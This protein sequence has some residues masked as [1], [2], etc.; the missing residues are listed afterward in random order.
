MTGGAGGEGV[1][2]VAPV[3]GVIDIAADDFDGAELD[4]RW[5]KNVTSPE[6][7]GLADG[8][9]ELRL[10]EP[11]AYSE[12][13]NLGQ[14]DVRDRWV[15]FELAEDVPVGTGIWF[16]VGS[17]YGDYVE[18]YVRGGDLVWYLE[19]AGVVDQST[20][21][22]FDYMAHRRLRIR[23]DSNASSD[24][25][26]VGE[27]YIDGQ[28]SVLFTHDDGIFD[29]RYARVF[30]GAHIL[31]DSAAPTTLR[32][33]AIRAL[34]AD[35]P[36]CKLG[37]LTDD[38]DTSDEP[39][40]AESGTTSCDL[41]QAGSATVHCTSSSSFV[42]LRSK[43]I[44]D[45]VDSGATIDLPLPVPARA[46]ASLHFAKPTNQDPNARD[47]VFAR[48]SPT[49]LRLEQRVNAAIDTLVSTNITGVVSRLGLRGTPTG[50]VVVEY[51]E[52][53]VA[54]SL[55]PVAAPFDLSRV[56]GRFGAG[57]G[58]LSEGESVTITFDHYNLGGE[59]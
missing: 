15:E 6:N 58:T 14:F 25:R 33:E 4:W 41:S 53:G 44:F 8:K 52:D 23:H 36:L 50:Q 38:F 28:W 31:D 42:A 12:I 29:P 49:D 40:V 2:P 17:N 56:H 39:W 34:Q 55:P 24:Q 54:K 59:P 22:P 16:A 48:L 13:Y 9:L 32:V 5:A 10:G 20:F 37:E 19:D 26:L 3:C 43:E 35:T 1:V 21:I 47:V 57:V 45:A 51:E 30:V 7:V 27:A 18:F 46:Y 11:D